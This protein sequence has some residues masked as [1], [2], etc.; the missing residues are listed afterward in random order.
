MSAVKY[1]GQMANGSSLRSDVKFYPDTRVFEHKTF[2][3]QN[4]GLLDLQMIGAINYYIVPTDCPVEIEPEDPDTS[5]NTSEKSSGKDKGWKEDEK[6]KNI[7]PKPLTEEEKAAK[8]AAD[9]AVNAKKEYDYAQ[10]AAN[11]AK[12]AADDLARSC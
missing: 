4:E 5:D 11:D 6:N 8:K 12:K 2:D 10:K 7:N 1:S 3:F 9:D